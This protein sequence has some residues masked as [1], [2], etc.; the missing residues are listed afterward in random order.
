ML[1]SLYMI[2]STRSTGNRAPEE[3]GQVDLKAIRSLISILLLTSKKIYFT[4]CFSL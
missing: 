3:V 4:H 2:D 1:P